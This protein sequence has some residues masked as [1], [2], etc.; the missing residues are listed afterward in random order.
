[1]SKVGDRLSYNTVS[2]LYRIPNAEFP[3][4]IG[5][6]SAEAYLRRLR[7]RLQAMGD[8]ELIKFG[9]YARSL[10]GIR[11]SGLPDPYK[12]QLDE[13]RREWRRRHPKQ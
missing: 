13:A 10:V 11:V 3:S 1:M 5:F 7:E 4:M 6:E 9:K 12:I 2:L 8:E